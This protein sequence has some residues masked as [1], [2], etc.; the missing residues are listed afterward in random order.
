MGKSSPIFLSS[1]LILSTVSLISLKLAN[2]KSTFKLSNKKLRTT[3][4]TTFFDLFPCLL[5]ANFLT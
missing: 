4:A 2:L 5:K 3:R 1:A